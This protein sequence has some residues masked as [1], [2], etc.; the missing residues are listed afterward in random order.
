M[1]RRPPSGG[2]KRNSRLALLATVISIRAK[3][4]RARIK[5]A[6]RYV[7][8]CPEAFMQRIICLTRKTVIPVGRILASLLT[9]RA[10]N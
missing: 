3:S 5:R 9:L 10:S 1:H 4:Q 2:G 8:V 6:G 7:Y